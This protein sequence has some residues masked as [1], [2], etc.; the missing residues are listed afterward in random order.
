MDLKY[1]LPLHK[2]FELLPAQLIDRAK[3]Q[4]AS[5][6]EMIAYDGNECEVWKEC[7]Y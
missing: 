2:P 6:G 3:E 7:D 5:F 4:K 1:R